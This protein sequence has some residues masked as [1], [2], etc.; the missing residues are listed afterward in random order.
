MPMPMP[1]PEATLPRPLIQVPSY[2]SG[3]QFFNNS[4]GS[5]TAVTVH[6]TLFASVKAIDLGTLGE[7]SRYASG[8]NDSKTIAAVSQTAS[9]AAHAFVYQSGK[10]TDLGTLY[11]NWQVGWFGT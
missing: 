9:G 4:A 7:H 3:A 2:F 8:F 6:A 5:T 10:M 1:G 11:T